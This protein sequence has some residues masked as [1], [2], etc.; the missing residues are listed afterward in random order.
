M[1]TDLTERLPDPDPVASRGHRGHPPASR[2]DTNEMMETCSVLENSPLQRIKPPPPP[3]PASGPQ[4]KDMDE[5]QGR[6]VLGMRR[7]EKAGRAQTLELGLC[8]WMAPS[9]GPEPPCPGISS[10]NLSVCGEY[11]Q[12]LCG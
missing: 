8:M 7:R 12:C 10:P 6:H 2:W 11:S 1:G 9:L 5:Q 3:P 4:R